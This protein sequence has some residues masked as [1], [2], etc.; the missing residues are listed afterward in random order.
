MAEDGVGDEGG[1]GEVDD[2]GDVGGGGGVECVGHVG[3]LG[4]GDVGCEVVLEDWW[5]SNVVRYRGSVN[6]TR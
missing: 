2:G 6:A 4:G 3:G 1:D 5:I